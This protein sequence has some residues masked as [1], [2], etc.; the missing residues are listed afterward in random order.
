ML[1]VIKLLLY[2]YTQQQRMKWAKDHRRWTKEVW[3]K[4]IFSDECAFE[5]LPSHQR[6]VRKGTEPLTPAHCALSVKFPQK[7]MIWGCMSS[8]GFGGLYFVDG[9][10][11][12]EQYE[13][14]L[15]TKLIP[16]ATQWFRGD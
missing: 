5:V 15:T 7:V 3:R 2:I 11:N 8:S 12:S 6:Y 14:V 9:V 13:M 16:Q 10:L 1:V 4:V